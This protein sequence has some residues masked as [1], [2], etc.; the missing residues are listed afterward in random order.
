MFS[1]LTLFFVNKIANVFH[2]QTMLKC[3]NIFFLN[4][5][6]A[7]TGIY[8]FVVHEFIYLI[9]SDRYFFVQ[10]LF[11]MHL[12]HFN[13]QGKNLWSCH[14]VHTCACTHRHTHTHTRTKLVF[15]QLSPFRNIFKV[16]HK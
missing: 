1:F 14:F 15:I 4:H 10:L 8:Q 7:K 9:F 2:K 6:P 11:S 5:H 13:N 3:L 16:A 12:I